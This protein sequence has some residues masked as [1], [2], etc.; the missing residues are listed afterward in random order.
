[1]KKEM[2]QYKTFVLPR[3]KTCSRFKVRAGV[4][5]QPMNS[6]PMGYWLDDFRN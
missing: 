4:A 2:Q 5:R 6:L 3:F 1:V